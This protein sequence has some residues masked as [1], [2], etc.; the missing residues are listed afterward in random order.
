MSYSLEYSYDSGFITS[1]IITIAVFVTRASL[2]FCS[3]SS[4]VPSITFSSS[5]LA[6]YMTAAGVE[7]P[8]PPFLASETISFRRCTLR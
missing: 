8:Y 2:T 7:S 6:L 4:R 5:Q 1:P 3:I